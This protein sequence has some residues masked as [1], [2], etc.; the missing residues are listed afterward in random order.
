MIYTL[1]AGK[2]FRTQLQYRAA[3]M[4]NNVASAIFGFVYIAIWQAATAGGDGVGEYTPYILVSYVA[5]NQA[6]LWLTTFFAFGLGIPERV[7]TGSVSLDMMRP[8]GLFSQTLSREAGSV[9]YNLIYRSVPVFIVLHIVLNVFLPSRMATVGWGI[10]AL[11]LGAYVGLCLA[12]LVGLSA[13]WTTEARWAQWAYLTLHAGLSGYM[14]PLDLLPG[15]LAVIAPYLPFSAQ[16][17]YPTRIWLEL[18]GIGD[19]MVPLVWAILLTVIC[20]V[21]TARARRRIEVQ[22]G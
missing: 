12:Y 11:A 2:G 4:V 15:K 22:G 18:A 21:G 5:Y 8:I 6:A 13:F 19:L 3:H 20:T 10:V 16:N 14:V 17:Y 7:R 9:V 1:L